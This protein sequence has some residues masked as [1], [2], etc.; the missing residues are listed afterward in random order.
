ML[1]LSFY[2][3]IC[4]A[5]TDVTPPPSKAAGPVV[6]ALPQPEVQ[7]FTEAEMADHV[8]AV[9]VQAH[10]RWKSACWDSADPA[11][12]KPGR[13]IASLAFDATG[14][15][16]ISGVGEIRESSDPAIAQ[17]LRRQV[18]TFTIPAPGHPVSYDVPFQMP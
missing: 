8:T 18:N 17:C 6:T 12:R 7:A 14:R 5:A 16:I 9:V 4:T 11:T 10:S 15:L 13:Y 2:F 3:G 1:A